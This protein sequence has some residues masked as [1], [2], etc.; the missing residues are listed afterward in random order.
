MGPRPDS[1]DEEKLMRTIFSL[2]C[3]RA[4]Q[5]KQEILQQFSLFH[6]KLGILLSCKDPKATDIMNTCVLL[7]TLCETL[8]QLTGV[9]RNEVEE[10]LSMRN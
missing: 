9:W 5:H 3:L 4:T 1:I 8:E 7:A 10:Y 6:E 2:S